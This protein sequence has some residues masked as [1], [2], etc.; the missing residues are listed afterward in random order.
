MAD[1]TFEGYLR[2]DGKVGIRNHVLLLGADRYANMLLNRVATWVRGTR[3]LVN[4]GEF[5]RPGYDREILLRFLHGIAYNPNTAAIIVMGMGPVYGY[6][7]FHPAD[8]AEAVARSGK[9]VEMVTVEEENGMHQAIGKAVEIARVMVRDASRLR[10]QS[11]GMDALTL[12]VKCGSSDPC[13]GIAGNLTIGYLFDKVVA[14]G[15]TAIFDET[16]E[17]IGAEHIVARRFVDPKEGERF[18]VLVAEHEARAK[19]TG[20]DIRTINPIPANIHAGI[21]TLEEK[22]LGAIGKSG[23]Q[24]I[25]GVLEYAQR[26]SRPG[27]WFMDGWPVNFSLLPGLAACGANITIY[28]L[29]GGDLPSDNPPLPSISSPVVAPVFFTTGNPRTYARAQNN[30]DFG[31]GEVVLGKETL[32]QASERLIQKILS[33]ASGEYTK[34]ETFN[35]DETAE[36]PFRGPLL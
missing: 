23:T 19:A 26:P 8:I 2:P 7:G 4:P 30:L 17:V 35:Y 36:M 32:E 15:G 6:E 31:S 27:L 3:Q 9:P 34:M 25:Q 20:E 22:S 28:Q 21:S 11:F 1:H 29:G 13:S 18:L 16:T 10:R 33:V 12:G 14:A 5:G 24:P